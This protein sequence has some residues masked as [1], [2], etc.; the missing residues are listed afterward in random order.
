MNSNSSRLLLDLF[1]TRRSAHLR[2]RPE[3]F[4]QRLLLLHPLLQ[5]LYMRGQRS[6]LWV[7]PD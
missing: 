5:H 2:L 1:A 4:D 3:L 6:S 7:S